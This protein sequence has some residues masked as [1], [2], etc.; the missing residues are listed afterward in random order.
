[1]LN[2]IVFIFGLNYHYYAHTMSAKS[3]IYEITQLNMPGVRP[4]HN[5]Q[6]LCKAIKLDRTNVHYITKFQPQISM[7]RAHHMLLF[8]CDLPGS[9][10]EHNK[11]IKAR[12]Y[13]RDCGEMTSQS[14]TASSSLPVCDPSGK[15][16]II[17]GWAKDAPA[18]T[19]PAGTGFKVAGN[20]EVQYLVLQVHYMHPLQGD[21]TLENYFKIKLNILEADF[22]G[23]T[24]TSTTTPMP[25]LAGVLLIAT[26]G[27]IKANSKENFEAA[28]LIDEDVE[29]HPFAFRVHAHDRGIVVSGF[30]VHGDR[31]DL[32]GKKSPKEPQMF[33]PVNNTDMVI[34]KNDIV[35]ARCT[36]ENIEDRDIKIGATGDDE[37][38]NFYI[39]YFVQNG[40]ILKDNTCTSAG[41]PI[42]YWGR[43]GGLKNIPDKFASTL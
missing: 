12:Q 43:D 11:I 35:A 25:N 4:D 1:M 14:N 32:I 20:T 29:I 37:M 3:S 5:E 22:S 18:L 38:C 39:M 26:D 9:D 7:S 15:T 8:G 28:C 2:L 24:L 10:E 42:Y 6:Y 16:S 31:W 40:S 13:F 21:V 27:M 30:K 36:M 41:P 17:Y 34:R 33:Y 23:V 19:L